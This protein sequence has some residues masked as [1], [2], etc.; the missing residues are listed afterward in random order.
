MASISIVPTVRVCFADETE[1]PD[2]PINPGSQEVIFLPQPLGHTD[3][4]YLKVTL[5]IL[6]SGI[7]HLQGYFRLKLLTDSD[8]D[9]FKMGN[10]NVI[11]Y[12]RE[13]TDGITIF[14]PFRLSNISPLPGA[15]VCLLRIFARDTAANSP[16]STSLIAI[17]PK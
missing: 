16:E 14:L 11:N 10:E 12:Y 13:I 3:I 15:N 7:T 8:Y 2:S 17:T 5:Q 4:H 1:C 9:F 6:T